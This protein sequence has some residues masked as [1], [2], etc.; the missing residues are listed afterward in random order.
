[1]RIAY[2]CTDPGIPVFGNK[3]A[4]IHAQA[5][6]TEFVLAGH[7]VHLLTPRPG[8]DPPATSPLRAVPVHR[9]PTVGRGPAAER[10]R[11]AQGSDRAVP[12]ILD[13]LAPDLL[14][15]RYALWG[16]SATSWAERAGVPAVLEVN[17]PLVE[18]QQRFRE[19]VDVTG[20]HEVTRSAFSAATAVVCVS[21]GVAAWART[22][23]SRPERVHVVANGVDPTRIQPRTAPV[24]P[25]D[26]TRFTVGFLGTLKAWHGVDLLVAA[27][28][29]LAGTDPSW[30]LLVVGD[31]PEREGLEDQVRRLSL[32]GRVEFTGALAPEEIS[33]QLQRMDVACAPYGA[34]DHGYFSPLKIYEYLAAGLPIVASDLGQ[35]PDALDHGALGRLVP[36]GDVPA[37]VE[38]LAAVRANDSW[39]CRMRAASRE[40][41]LT[42][43]SWRSVVE[44]ILAIARPGEARPDRPSPA[45]LEAAVGRAA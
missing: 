37:L 8:D 38:A 11:A 39:R 36:A 13:D 21:A 10:E 35:I 29:Q 9:L 27:L 26:T 23:S 7:E 1:M 28:A 44:R 12:G 42:R 40:V 33:G 20:A 30:H 15:E 24:T 41:A 31:G 43:H 4:S 16:R 17:A 2:V 19:L 25:A 6:L 14:Y 32:S 34:G 45:L 3:G 18:E 22:V 5:V